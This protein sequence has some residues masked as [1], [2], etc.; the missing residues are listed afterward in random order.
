M[1]S[2]WHYAL[3]DTGPPGRPCLS[4]Q[5]NTKALRPGGIGWHYFQLIRRILVRKL[6]PSF[7]E[8]AGVLAGPGITEI[9]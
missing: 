9:N 3:P 5:P 2:S 1:L 6:S 8:A 4:C 7:K